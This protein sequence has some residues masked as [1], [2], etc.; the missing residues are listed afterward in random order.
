[1]V[2]GDGLSVQG[3]GAEKDRAFTQ[4][5]LTPFSSHSC[6]EIQLNEDDVTD[7]RERG[8]MSL[9]AISMLNDSYALHQK[10]VLSRTSFLF[11]FLLVYHCHYLKNIKQYK[12]A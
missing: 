4:R 2:G 7:Q 3:S 6:Q 8:I 11:F 12:Q 10:C 9:K 1:M 5:T